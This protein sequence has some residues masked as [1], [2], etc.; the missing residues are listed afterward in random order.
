MP[1]P[2]FR[3]ALAVAALCLFA[4]PASAVDKAAP[5]SAPSLGADTLRP[6]APA[7]RPYLDDAKAPDSVAILPA[8]PA[9][10]SAAETADK[11]M[12]STTRSR[13]G[14]ARWDLA[15]A[16]VAEGSEAILENLACVLGTR[17]DVKRV[18]A[19][20]TLLER[21]RLDIARATRMAKVHYRRLRPFVGNEQPI[22]VQRNQALADSYSYPSGHASQGW[23][24][25]LIM[26]S[27]VPEKATAILT[28]G[29]LYGES[30]VV[31]G[32]H[33]LS[34]VEAGRTNGAAVYAALQ[35]DAGFRADME[36]ARGEL[37]KAM[38]DG[39]S[40]PEERTCARETAAAAEPAL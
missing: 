31:C 12:F 20:L 19:L 27:L 23:T 13:Q 6:G 8:P 34:D 33:W 39:R 29:R 18:P 3:S 38:A 17:I 24:Y 36:K 14:G 32:V 7:P 15:A 25:A 40:P 30:R 4:A 10:H 35:G 1:R 22:C 5:Q 21:A 28:R 16:D 9:S 11:V 37:G 2:A 26:A